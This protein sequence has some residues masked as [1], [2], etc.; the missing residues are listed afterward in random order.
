MFE[1]LPKDQRCISLAWTW[2][3]WGCHVKIVLPMLRGRQHAAFWSKGVNTVQLFLPMEPFCLIIEQLYWHRDSLAGGTGP[4][5][6]ANKSSN[7]LKLMSV[8]SPLSQT[9][10]Q[11]WVLLLLWDIEW[12]IRWLTNTDPYWPYWNLPEVPCFRNEITA[13]DA[14]ACWQWYTVLLITVFRSKPQY[15]SKLS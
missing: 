6:D 10:P 1:K 2:L 12:C 5:Q 3:L 13:G 15:L 8:H 4:Q 9:Y 7:T 14:G 11:G